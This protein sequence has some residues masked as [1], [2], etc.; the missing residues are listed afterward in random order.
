M[1]LDPHAWVNVSALEFEFKNKCDSSQWFV[2]CSVLF[3][4]TPSTRLFVFVTCV[5]Q[6]E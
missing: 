5:S 4:L 3:D 2:N 6:S 1:Y